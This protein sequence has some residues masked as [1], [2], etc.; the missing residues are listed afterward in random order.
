VTSADLNGDDYDDVAI[1]A[2]RGRAPRVLGLDGFMLGERSRRP[3][4]RLFSFRAA[5]GRKA[6]VNLASGY[7]DPRTRPGPVANLITTPQSGPRAGRVRVWT[8]M[9][10]EEHGSSARMGHLRSTAT[11]QPLR[12]RVRGGLRLAVTRLG[13]QGVNAL[14]AW[15]NPRKPRYVSINDEGVVSNIPTPIRK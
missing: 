6:G 9:L 13:K 5:R 2:G 14:A 3:P 7:Y 11:L 1:G 8:P 12:R 15:R 4:A 10:P